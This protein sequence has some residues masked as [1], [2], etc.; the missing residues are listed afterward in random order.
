MQKILSFIINQIAAVVLILMWIVLFGVLI[1]R[2]YENKEIQ[3]T[4][5]EQ[6]VS[7]SIDYGIDLLRDNSLDLN[8][9]ELN[10]SPVNQTVVKIKTSAQMFNLANNVFYTP[11]GQ[12]YALYNISTHKYNL[13]LNKSPVV[14]VDT[15]EIIYA[16]SLINGH[17]IL[18]FNDSFIDNE[19]YS[20]SIL[21][22]TTNSHRIV[23]EIGNYRKIIE[24]SINN[25]SNCIQIKFEDSR[26]YSDDGDY[27]LYQYCGN[28]IV[29]KVMSVKSDDYYKSKFSALTASDIYITALADNCIESQ[30]GKFF[31]ERP[32]SNGQKYCHM[33]KFAKKT[34]DQEYTLMQN[35]CR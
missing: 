26:T 15:P 21:D 19:H 16:F 3:K 12:V 17:V 11:I 9:N 8:I 25:Y 13:Y 5:Q 35:L 33:M 31:K 20:Y 18:I 27:E 29:S 30:T 28:S 7:Q 1:Y 14:E 6:Q 34:S 10:E 23:H 4:T 22:M 24:A 2:H 32:C